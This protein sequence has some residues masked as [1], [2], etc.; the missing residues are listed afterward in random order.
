MRFVHLDNYLHGNCKEGLKVKN[1]EYLAPKTIDEAIALLAEHR[2]KAIVYNGGT[3]IMISLRSMTNAGF[4]GP[5]YV[6]RPNI[7]GPDYVVDIKKIP[8]LKEITFSKEEGLYVGCCATLN[9]IAANEYVRQYYPYYADGCAA[10]GSNQVRNRGTCIGNIC[11]ASPL[12]DSVTPL[13]LVDAVLYLQGPKGKREVPV[14]DFITFVKRT[15]IEPDEIV[16]G[17]RLPYIEGLKAVYTKNARRKQVDLSNVCATIGKIGDEYRIAF[18]SVAPTPIRLTKT[19]EFL[20]GKK[21]DDAVI[22]QAQEIALTE[23]A[24][25][26][27]VRASKL[28]RLDI[29]K[30]I[31]ENSLKELNGMR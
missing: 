20:K 7:S 24:P 5:D 26:D 13:Y 30:A 1:F 9:E 18:G 15:I 11:N 3:D 14:K 19:E 17:V 21:I 12:A 25:I 2:G 22:A 16:L 28:Y 8:G 23:V 31:I 6:L 27:D 4:T 10:V 29:V